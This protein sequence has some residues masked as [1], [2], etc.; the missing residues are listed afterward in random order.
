MWLCPLHCGFREH[1]G[2]GDT[3]SCRREKTVHRGSKESQTFDGQTGGQMEDR[4][5]NKQIDHLEV[6]FLG[7]AANLSNPLERG[8]RE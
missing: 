2:H 3:L 1:K 4:E 8:S 6:T 5:I 7:V